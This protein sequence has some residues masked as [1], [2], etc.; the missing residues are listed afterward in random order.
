MALNKM[1][2]EQAPKLEAGEI[3]VRDLED[4]SNYIQKLSMMV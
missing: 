3:G 1:D 2:L 4:L